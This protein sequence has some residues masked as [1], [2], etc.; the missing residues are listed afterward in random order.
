M[1]FLGDGHLRLRISR[2]CSIQF[3]F[4][5]VTK[6]FEELPFLSLKTEETFLIMT[7]GGIISAFECAAFESGMSRVEVSDFILKD[8]R[9]FFDF[10]D[11]GVA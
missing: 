11:L 7:V 1:K 8:C 4:I 6:F 2:A 5:S 3:N 10:N 9:N